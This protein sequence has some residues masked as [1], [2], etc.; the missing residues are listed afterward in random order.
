LETKIPQIFK[1][2]VYVRTK[3]RYY[4]FCT[5]ECAKTIDEYLRYRIRCGE[6]LK[7]ESPLFRKGFNKQ[8]PFTIN[9][10]KFLSAV[11]LLGHLMR[12]S[13]DPE[14]IHLNV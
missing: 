12:S 2:Q 10:P 13:R 14:L 5:P 6:H 4:T 8:D 9:V 11:E 1:V 3:D 7:D